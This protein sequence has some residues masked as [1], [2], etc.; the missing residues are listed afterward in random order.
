MKDGKGLAIAAVIAGLGLWAWQKGKVATA[1]AGKPATAPLEA[2]ATET[3]RVL[4][5]KPTI[6]GEMSQRTPAEIIEYTV[7]PNVW[8]ERKI[9]EIKAAGI[10]VVDSPELR[11][12]IIADYQ[13][14]LTPETIDWQA[15]VDARR[16]AA[17]AAPD[18]MTRNNETHAA[19][20]LQYAINKGASP[21]VLA[22][23][24]KTYRTDLANIEVA[25]AA[26][27]W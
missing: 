21:E 19:D 13:A 3:A 7:I 8:V 6:I 27:K 14:I 5:K 26:G 11:K 10:D 12:D 1:P 23:V 9:E 4:V 22:V 20:T 24:A 25:I 16:A 15:V 2:K 18:R 17:A